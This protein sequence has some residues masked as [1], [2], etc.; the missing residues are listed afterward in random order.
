VSSYLY[1]PR[2]AE[3]QTETL[4]ALDVAAKTATRTRGR[5]NS[6][7]AS[8]DKS[9]RALN[10]SDRALNTSD[11]A[12]NASDSAPDKSDR[13]TNKSDRATNKSDTERAD[14]VAH[15]PVFEKDRRI[16]L[17][18]CFALAVAALALALNPS[19]ALA[20]GADNQPTT[21]YRIADNLY[22][23]GASDI[24]VYLVTT[25]AGSILIDAGYKETPPI[26]KANIATLGLK[27]EDIKIILNTQAHYDHSAGLAEMKALTHAQMV[28]SEGDAP[29]LEAGGHGDYLFGDRYPFPP[30]KVDRRIKDGDEVKLGGTV[31]TARVTPGH[32][33]GCT[34]WTM[35]VRDR[36]KVLKMVLVGGTSINPGTKVSGMPTY[37]TIT[38]DFS[39]TFETLKA[40][41]CDI[42]LGA[43]RA[44][45]GGAEKAKR[46]L[47]NPDGPNPFVDPEGYKRFVDSVEKRFREQLAAERK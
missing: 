5:K 42:F 4:S 21:P 8:P 35:D 19:Q 13:A 23:V 14:S 36:G 15:S 32:T 6:L 17:R 46:L 40:M 47:A 33:K 1:I 30:V 22:Y 38:R 16:V 31:L 45:Y 24:A 12:P 9:D 27:V 3:A 18:H 28:A 34:T 10:T 20:Q 43:H 44:Y 2:V 26:I 41:P 7:N 39:Y 25:P 37:P 29:L 11:S